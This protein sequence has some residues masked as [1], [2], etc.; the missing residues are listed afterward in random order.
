MARGP[1]SGSAVPSGT[2]NDFFSGLP[3]ENTDREDLYK[4]WIEVFN[5][6]L[7]TVLPKG[8]WGH[9]DI[10][11]VPMK[12]LKNQMPQYLKHNDG[13]HLNYEGNR[14][15]MSIIK[16]KILSALH[17]FCMRDLALSLG[18]SWLPSVTGLVKAYESMVPYTLLK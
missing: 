14:K 16:S 4:S 15:M 6:A 12:G 2:N 11:F 8:L 7:K 1:N 13:K 10:H 3:G 9:P 17:K 18:A 5:S